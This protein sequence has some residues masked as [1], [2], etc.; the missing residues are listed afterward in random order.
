MNYK[1]TVEERFIR[2]AKIDT[3]ADPTSTTFPSSEIQKNLG[4]L[5]VSELQDLGAIDVEMD[6]WGYVWIKPF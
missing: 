3:T 4:R 5:L 6:K 1:H 2:Y